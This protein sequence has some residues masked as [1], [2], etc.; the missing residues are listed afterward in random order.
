MNPRQLWI[1]DDTAAIRE[2]VPEVAVVAPRNQL[3]GYQGGNN[4][5]RGAKS[6]NFQVMGDTP[7]AAA[8][9]RWEPYTRQE[10]VGATSRYDQQLNAALERDVMT[11]E[12]NRKK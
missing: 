8:A 10:V 1:N 6:G 12:S 11:L 9:P 2:Q 5:S 3:R 4:V 7:E